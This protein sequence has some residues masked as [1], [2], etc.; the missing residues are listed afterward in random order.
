MLLNHGVPAAHAAGRL[1]LTHMLL[2]CVSVC[3]CVCCAP[4]LCLRTAKRAA[5]P[6]VADILSDPLTALASK[7]WSQVS[8]FGGAAT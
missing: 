1:L 4:C 3:L 8:R 2:G 7:N 5:A 6:T